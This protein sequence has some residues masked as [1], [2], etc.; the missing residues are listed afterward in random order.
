MNK[1]EQL[2]NFVENDE[3][4]ARYIFSK[5][6]F[7]KQ[8][9]R[10]KHHAFMP[11]TKNKNEISV[12]RHKNCSKD[13]ILKIG[14]KTANF[15]QQSLKAVSSIRAN[16][17]RSINDLDVESDTSKGQHRRHANITG[18]HNY[19][20]AKVRNIAQ[21]LADSAHLLYVI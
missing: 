3:P 8:N 14:R 15:R 4:L 17:V 16:Q 5:T 10:V 21:K 7:S 20:D 9:N 11:P 6:D 1:S 2:N 13:C 18:F 12:I 19:T